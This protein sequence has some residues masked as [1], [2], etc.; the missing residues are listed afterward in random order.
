MASPISLTIEDSRCWTTERVTGSIGSDMVALFFAR[1]R[2][3]A[4]LIAGSGEV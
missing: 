2:S 4:Y 3:K 1:P